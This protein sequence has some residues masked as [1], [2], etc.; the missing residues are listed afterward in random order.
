MREIVSEKNFVR[1]RSLAKIKRC[2][3]IE[4]FEPEQP[5]RQ[6]PLILP[7]SSHADKGVLFRRVFLKNANT[8]GWFPY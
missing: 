6:V 5:F 2:A 1:T 3:R 7:D 4:L 8:P